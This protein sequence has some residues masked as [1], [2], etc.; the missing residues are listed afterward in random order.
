MVFL[1]LGVAKLFGQMKPKPLWYSSNLNY[2][3]VILTGLMC[4]NTEIIFR[5]HFNK[6]NLHLEPVLYLV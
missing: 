5:I 6:K 2:S 4:I 1:V 3:T